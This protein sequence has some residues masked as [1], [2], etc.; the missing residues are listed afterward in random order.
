MN[1]YGKYSRGYKAGGF[2]SG[3]IVQLPMTEPE[4]VDAFEL[5]LKQQIGGQLQINASLFYYSYEGMQ[6]PLSVIPA[7]GP[8]QTQF[9]N[10]DKVTSRGAEL[11]TIWQPTDALQILFNYA[12][13]DAKIDK[14]C[15]FVD[16]VDP[17][18]IQP[19]AQPSG[20]LTGTSQGQSLTGE[21]VPQSPEHKAALNMNYTFRLAPGSLNVSVSDIWK[22]AT[23]FSVFNRPY[24]L[25]PSYNQIDLRA[26]WTAASDHYSIVAFGRNILDD[27]GYDGTTGLLQTQLPAGG[28]GVPVIPA[29]ITR[30]V[31]L[32]P[33]RTYGVELQYRF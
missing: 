33:P 14:G 11:E 21:R 25:A 27:E 13:L 1:I 28:V 16:G 30:N 15:C 3:A 17:R 32:T 24:N 31:S 18:A 10:M 12:Y 22:D 26:T 23:Y 6:I 19:D 29:S 9:F 4:T 5:G 2:N 8:T 7:A 20:P